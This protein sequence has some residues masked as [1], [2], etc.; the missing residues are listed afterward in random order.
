VKARACG[1]IPQVTL[2][3]SSYGLDS[4]RGY[5]V[6]RAV[7]SFLGRGDAVTV[8]EIYSKRVGVS[9]SAGKRR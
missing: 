2:Q 6:Q 5:I 9:L 4:R 7:A 3:A 8:T 1:G